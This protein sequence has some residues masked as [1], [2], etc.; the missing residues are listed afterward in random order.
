MQG[1][2][3]TFQQ[4]EDIQNFSCG[5]SSFPHN[6]TPI[7]MLSFKKLPSVLWEK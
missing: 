4:E 5:I 6:F 2:D 3:Y 7:D 1:P